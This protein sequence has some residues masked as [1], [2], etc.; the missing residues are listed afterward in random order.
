MSAI[1]LNPLDKQEWK[2]TIEMFFGGEDHV[3]GRPKMKSSAWSSGEV[4][5]RGG[6]GK[7]V[8]I[9][10]W[11]GIETWGRCTAKPVTK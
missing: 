3:A 9:A 6:C 5:D 2:R 8:Q 10:F 11:Q 1:L 4:S 7:G